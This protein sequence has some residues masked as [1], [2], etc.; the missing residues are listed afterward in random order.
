MMNSLVK[1]L[2]SPSLYRLRQRARVFNQ[3]VMSMLVAFGLKRCSPDPCIFSLTS[4]VGKV[5]FLVVG[6]SADVDN[7]I[8][9]GEARTSRDLRSFLHKFFPM[10]DLGRLSKHGHDFWQRSFKGY[11]ERDPNRLY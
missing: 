9:T 3:L 1:K 10:K 7:L 6:A 2:K 8:V 5:R 11:S 4:L